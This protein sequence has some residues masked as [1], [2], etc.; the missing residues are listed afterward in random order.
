MG[1]RVY[2]SIVVG[3]GGMGAAAI[4]AL[5]RRGRRVLGLDRSSSGGEQDFDSASI[6]C[7]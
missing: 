2:D 7:D 6:G 5:A 3:V 4:Y 1:Q